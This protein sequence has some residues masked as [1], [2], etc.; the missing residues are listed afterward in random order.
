MALWSMCNALRR[1][2]LPDRRV[3]VR[4]AFNWRPHRE[5]NWLLIELDVT[6]ICRT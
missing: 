6:E 2:L 1:D 4:F 5:R 3:V